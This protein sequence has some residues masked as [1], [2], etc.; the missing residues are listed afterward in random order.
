MTIDE[1]IAEIEEDSARG[2]SQQNYYM[3]NPARRR[4]REFTPM[5]RYWEREDELP[6]LPAT[7]IPPREAAHWGAID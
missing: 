7:I 6:T 2:Q 1:M 5:R 3:W 4:R